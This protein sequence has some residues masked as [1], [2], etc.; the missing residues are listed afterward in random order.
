MVLLL[1]LF[2]PI[3]AGAQESVPDGH[4]RWIGTWEEVSGRGTIYDFRFEPGGAVQVEK[5]AGSHFVSERLAWRPVGDDIQLSGPSAGIPELDNAILKKQ[6]AE[7]FTLDI[8]GG[9]TINVRRSIPA[10]SWLHAAFLFVFL[11]VANEICRRF[12]L[13]PYIAFFVLPIVL[14]PVFMES[15]FDTMFRWVKLYSAVVGGV[16]FTLVRFNGLDKYRWARFAVAFILGFNILEACTQDYSNHQLANYLNAL[17]GILNIVT[18]SRWAGIRRD[19]QPPHDMLW[20]GMTVG[21][22]IAY[23]IWNFTFVYLNFPNTALFTLLLVVA[24]TLAA[25]FIK[26]GTWMQARAY[27]L[28]IYMMYIFSLRAF[29]EHT[30]NLQFV[31]PLPRSESIALTLAVL[32]LAANLIYAI[33]HFRWRLTGKAP[34]RLQVGQ[35]ES[36]I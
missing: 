31:V 28:S 11:L 19:D 22:I 35:N 34:K 33:L 12:K 8:G 21:W 7:H 4:K 3:I 10:L 25:I 24:P 16:F 27:T 13:A 6:S 29:A 9:K 32:S 2:L 1:L 17:A 20:P 36:V 23:D 30:L 15:G 14:I 5:S 18:I 26:K